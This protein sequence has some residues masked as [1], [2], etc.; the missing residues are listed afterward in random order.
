MMN[1]I[2]YQRVGQLISQKG[3]TDIRPTKKRMRIGKSVWPGESVVMADADDNFCRP[4]TLEDLKKIIR[5]LN[6][7]NAQYILIGGY[8]LFSH[9]YHRATEDIDL[10]VP[11]KS[12]SSQD[13]IEAL[14]VLA[15]GESANL[16]PGW[17]EE[18]ENIRLAD[19]IVVD[20]IFRTCGETYES[21]KPYVEELDLDGISVLTLSLEGL[22]KTK[23]SMRHKDVMDRAVLESA[24]G[25][26]GG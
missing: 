11:A 4:A 19:E 25:K 15:D 7:H 14:L 3:Y 17:F 8:A 26:R 9:G 24:L 6:E 22:L 21:L 18:G 13:I 2:V 1:C 23:Q 5:S 12:T 10:L 16:E 20:L